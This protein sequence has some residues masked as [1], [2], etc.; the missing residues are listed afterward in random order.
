[1]IYTIYPNNPHIIYEGCIDST[2]TE[3]K[4]VFY[5]FTRDYI[6]QGDN[7]FYSI[8]NA[9]NSSGISI[10]FKTTSP[11]VKA[12][13]EESF[14]YIPTS[15]QHD[16][17][18]FKNNKLLSTS[19]HLEFIL[20]NPNQ[21]IV[22][23]KLVMPIFS[24]MIF[25]GLELEEVDHLVPIED[26]KKLIYISIGDSITQGY[27]TT[28][29]AGH[30]A[31]PF[32]VAHELNYSLYNWGISGSKV[33]S[34]ILGNFETKITPQLISVLW[35]FNDMFFAWNDDYLG[36]YTF[37]MYK[38]LLSELCSRFPHSKI[39][40]ILPTYTNITTNTDILT[41]ENL[42][43]GE[44]EIIQELQKKHTNLSYIKG[45]DYTDHSSL[46]DDVH[47]SDYGNEQLANGII[48]YLTN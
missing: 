34:K 20:E 36:E 37:K 33:Y 22:E 35:G 18:I 38:E 46:S 17:A 27:G 13:F 30:L 2:I 47:L 31:Y 26:S 43:Q 9:A 15:F 48:K 8:K 16:I 10:I 39:L 44:L 21:E 7:D 14:S 28:G 40:A 42:I 41:I 25:L 24:Q 23:W 12:F 5:R 1:M 29:N 11:L 6:S 19:N 32:L 45:T 3:R 4:A